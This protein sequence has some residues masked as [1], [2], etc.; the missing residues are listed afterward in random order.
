MGFYGP[1]IVWIFLGYYTAT[2]WRDIPESIDCTPNQMDQVA[3]GLFFIKITEDGLTEKRGIA[4]VTSK[5]NA[6]LC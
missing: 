4:N 1:K 2:F 3:E 6:Y 5:L